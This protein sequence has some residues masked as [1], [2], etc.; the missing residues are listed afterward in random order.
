MEWK[1]EAGEKFAILPILVRA[2]LSIQ[3]ISGGNVNPVESKAC[4]NCRQEPE[5]RDSRS[6]WWNYALV[7]MVSEEGQD[8]W[9]AIGLPR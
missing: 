4:R 8:D 1:P 7:A 3:P 5:S 2:A 9:A 6:Y